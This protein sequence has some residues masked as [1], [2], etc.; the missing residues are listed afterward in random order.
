MYAKGKGVLKD[1]KETAKWYR[2]AAEQ[3]NICAQYMLY[4]HANK[5]NIDTNISAINI[6][7]LY[8]LGKTITY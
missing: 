6:R 1:F 7:L 8:Y 5:L 4:M 3:G 2:K